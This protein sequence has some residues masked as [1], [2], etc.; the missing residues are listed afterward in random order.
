MQIRYDHSQ[1]KEAHIW[2]DGIE[3]TASCLEAN[4][5]EGWVDIVLLNRLGLPIKTPH[6]GPFVTRVYGRVIIGFHK[7]YHNLSTGRIYYSPAAWA[8]S[9][10]A[11]SFSV[12]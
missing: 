9:L 1:A 10:L 4:S 3:L 7:L 12:N 2:L 8:H 6:G 11:H 5:D